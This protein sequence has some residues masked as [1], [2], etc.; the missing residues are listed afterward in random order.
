MQ[1]LNISKSIYYR[2]INRKSYWAA[3]CLLLFTR[4]CIILEGPNVCDS[5]IYTS[6]L[7]IYILPAMGKE[8]IY[9]QY[10]Y[11]TL[12]IYRQL[13]ELASGFYTFTVF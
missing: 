6:C 11:C 7:S 3:L 13:M 9:I 8:A 1:Y 4:Y 2:K 12:H 10:T 5:I